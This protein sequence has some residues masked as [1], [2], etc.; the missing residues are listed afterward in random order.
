MQ[1]GAGALDGQPVLHLCEAGHDVE[2]EPGG[3]GAGVNG[4]GE[5]L[6]VDVPRLQLGDQVDQELDAAPKP[7]ELPDH[8]RVAAAQNLQGTGQTGPVGA[9]AA[10]FVVVGVVSGNGKNR[11]LR[12]RAGPG[13][14]TG[15]GGGVDVEQACCVG[16]GLLSDAHE[17]HDF[18]LLAGG[19][20]GATSTDAAVVARGQQAVAGALAQH[21]ALE[22]GE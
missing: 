8:E 17:V 2:G 4:V 1:P 21:R 14:E 22:L 19:E 15:D 20:L 18:L 11:T 9:A 3:R 12:R 7:V 6:E 10:D 13:Q 5:A 16:G